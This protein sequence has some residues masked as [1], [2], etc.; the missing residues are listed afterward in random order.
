MLVETNVNSN[1]TYNAAID[2]SDLDQGLHQTYSGIDLDQSMNRY[3]IT[4]SNSSENPPVKQETDFHDSFSENGFK[5]RD[6]TQ[7][8]KTPSDVG[9]EEEAVYE[10]LNVLYKHD[11]ISNEGMGNGYVKENQLKPG[12]RRT[13]RVSPNFVTDN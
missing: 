2:A 10:N 3:H 11:A 5:T 6:G 12:I 13:G 4:H 9:K 1:P 7:R 8:G